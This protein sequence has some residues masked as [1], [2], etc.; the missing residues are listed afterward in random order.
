MKPAFNVYHRDKPARNSA[1]NAEFVLGSY[2]TREAAESELEDC[3]W[4]GCCTAEELVIREEEDLFNIDDEHPPAYVVS[5]FGRL[6]NAFYEAL[7]DERP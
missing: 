5:A 6:N 3:A 7:P 1:V 4:F 2:S